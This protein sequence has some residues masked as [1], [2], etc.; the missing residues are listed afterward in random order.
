MLS[1]G[2]SNHIFYLQ[3]DT[4]YINEIGGKLKRYVRH[5]KHFA[6]NSFSVI[7]YE[8]STCICDDYRIFRVPKLLININLDSLYIQNAIIGAK[9]NLDKED[10]KLIKTV[11]NAF[12]L[13]SS[14]RVTYKDKNCEDKFDILSVSSESSFVKNKYY[15][16]HNGSNDLNSR[17]L[18]DLL[19]PYLQY[20]YNIGFIDF[21]TPLYNIRTEVVQVVLK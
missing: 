13:D 12:T 11:F 15:F 4:F 9:Y 19:L 21:S 8:I 10:G 1:Y 20:K 3:D 17:V 2:Q 5:E 14:M 7:K 16:H 18:L 6:L